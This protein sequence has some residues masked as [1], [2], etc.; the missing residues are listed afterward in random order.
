MGKK[1][2]S[3]HPAFGTRRVITITLMIQ[4]LLMKGHYTYLKLKE[5]TIMEKTNNRQASGSKLLRGLVI[6]SAVGATAALLMTPKTG[7][8]MRETIRR[9]SDEIST[10]AKDRVASFTAQAKET[11]GDISDKVV[12][13]AGQAK[14]AAGDVG[15]KVSSMA[16]QAIGIV[17]NYTNQ[18]QKAGIAIADKVG[19]TA[20]KA[21]SA[22]EKAADH[23]K[24]SRNNQNN[25]N[26]QENE[27]IRSER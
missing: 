25:L 8:D 18:A 22:A 4:V 11:A 12:S 1:K 10:A 9:K 27:L 3:R 2:L 7:K 26:K 24:D 20:E 14:D 21:G 13:L 23:F 15:S 16:S 19:S 5:L 17:D 6:G